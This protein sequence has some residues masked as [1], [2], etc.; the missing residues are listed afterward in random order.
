MARTSE[1]LG[2]L[3]FRVQ[4]ALRKVDRQDLR[5]GPLPRWGRGLARFDPAG[6][7]EFRHSIRSVQMPGQ[8]SGV[9]Q[10]NG[11]GVRFEPE[12]DCLSPSLLFRTRKKLKSIQIK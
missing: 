5:T 12:V 10:T 1:G 2:F 11:V 9:L 7:A 3:H 4:A 6:R 8:A